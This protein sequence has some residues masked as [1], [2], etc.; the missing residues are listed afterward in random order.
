MLPFSNRINY[1]RRIATDI[2]TVPGYSSDVGWRKSAKFGG[3]DPCPASEDTCQQP[4][5]HLD[6]ATGQITERTTR[7]DHTV[8]RR[9]QSITTT[10]VSKEINSTIKLILYTYYD[11]IHR[12]ETQNREGNNIFLIQSKERSEQYWSVANNYKEGQINFFGQLYFISYTCCN[13]LLPEFYLA[14]HSKIREFPVNGLKAKVYIFPGYLYAGSEG[15]SQTEILFLMD[16]E[17]F[18]K[19]LIN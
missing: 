7:Y 14:P 13:T 2:S 5:I 19:H 8:H 6:T 17:P 3:S 4:H 10:L 18:Q 9:H 1:G 12:N 15:L 16:V 11:T